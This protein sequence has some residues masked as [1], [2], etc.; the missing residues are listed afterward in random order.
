MDETTTNPSSPENGFPRVIVPASDH[1]ELPAEPFHRR[2]IPATGQAFFVG[3]LTWTRS[4]KARP[5][6]LVRIFCPRCKAFHEHPWRW[7]WGL[8]DPDVVSYQLARCQDS[9]GGAYWVGLAPSMAALNALV[10]KTA[11]EAFLAWEAKGKRIREERERLKAERR[12]AAAE[13]AKPKPPVSGLWSA[14]VGT[15]KSKG[16]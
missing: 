14:P 1:L 9:N 6:M 12:A 4:P 3:R 13:A 2:D 10:H 11:R 5:L 8:D 15:I 7:D 16:D